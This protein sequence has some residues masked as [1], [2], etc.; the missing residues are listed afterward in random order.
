MTIDRLDAI[1]TF[2]EIVDAGSFSS[3]ARRLGVSVPAVSRR[4]ASFEERLGALLMNRTTRRLDLTEC[5]Q[6]YYD[7]AKRI[8]A[9]LDAA[10]SE[11]A[12]IRQSPAGL[13]KVAAPGVFGRAFVAPV[14][15]EF[16]TLYP[17]IRVDLSLGRGSE[18][19]EAADVD[20]AIQLG[21]QVQ[22]QGV[23]T[24]ALGSFRQVLCAAPDYVRRAG[25]PTRPEDLA[26]HDCILESSSDRAAAW[27]FR[28]EGR[29][30]E[31]PIQGRLVC[32]DSDAVLGAA[33]AG[34]GVARISSFQVREH[35]RDRRLEVLLEDFEPPPIPTFITCPKHAAAT[36]KVNAF[37]HFLAQSISQERL[38]L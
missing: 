18:T 28:R 12:D 23:A 32:D 5:G 14:I 10:E 27:R 25:A 37:V 16:L 21:P 13:L 8:L 1:K 3:A 22:S 4:L 24:R 31:L 15:P 11:L 19:T 38:G 26:Q 2:V 7:R 29:D 30:V 17:R 34:S 36:P 9:D 35:V 6:S 20:A 33:L